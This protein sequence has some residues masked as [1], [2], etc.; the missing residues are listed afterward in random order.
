MHDQKSHAE[1]TIIEDAVDTGIEAAAEY[2]SSLPLGQKGWDTKE[3]RIAETA[4][5]VAIAA[6]RQVEAGK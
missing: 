1:L 5:R 6:L 4:A 2:V 3:Y